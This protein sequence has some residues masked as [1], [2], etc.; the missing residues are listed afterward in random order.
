MQ[1]STLSSRRDLGSFQCGVPALDSYIKER[2]QMGRF[3][4]F[5]TGLTG[6]S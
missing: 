2:A 4:R 5:M 3:F 1:F 6:F